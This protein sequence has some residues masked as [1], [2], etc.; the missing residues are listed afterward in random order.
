MIAI[1]F[2][3]ERGLIKHFYKRPHADQIL[4]TFGLA[5]VLQEVIKYFYGANPIPTPAPEASPARSILARRLAL[6]RT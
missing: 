5:I 6:T 4:V 3:M 1:G 2:I